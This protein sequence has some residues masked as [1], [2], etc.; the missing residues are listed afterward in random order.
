LVTFPGCVTTFTALRLLILRLH[1]RLLLLFCCL[2]SARLPFTFGFASL[3]AVPARTFGWIL[4][5]VCYVCSVLRCL[6]FGWLPRLLRSA[7]VRS[8]L[9]FVCYV[10]V[11]RLVCSAVY[12]SPH[13]RLFTVC[14]WLFVAVG[15]FVGW[16][17]A[18]VCRFVYVYV[19]VYQFRSGSLVTF[20]GLYHVYVCL[21][22]TH[23]SRLPHVTVD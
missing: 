9:P 20:T 15:W 3:P 21:H 7:F 22:T 19:Y 4:R 13:L 11:T 6:P 12:G 18:F 1:G 16:F 8:L 14:G 5:F 17:V 2:R 10:T 23:R